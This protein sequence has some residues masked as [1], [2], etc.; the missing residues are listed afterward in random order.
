M[1]AKRTDALMEKLTCGSK[2]ALD[3]KPEL[4]RLQRLAKELFK[5]RSR[6]WGRATAMRTLASE[7]DH[8]RGMDKFFP[9]QKEQ[10]TLKSIIGNQLDRIVLER[11]PDKRT[12]DKR[13]LD[14]SAMINL[15]K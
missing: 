2:P 6:I 7:Y 14:V 4:I 10:G 13:G 15:L 11:P 3:L 12:F 9:R 1:S 5:E 8:Q